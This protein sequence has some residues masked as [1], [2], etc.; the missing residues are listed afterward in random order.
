MK[1]YPLAVLFFLNPPIPFY[2]LTYTVAAISEKPELNK[3]HCYSADA[4]FQTPHAK[5]EYQVGSGV[6][7]SIYI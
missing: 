7:R 2:K 3:A 1:F 4:L 5:K 6:F